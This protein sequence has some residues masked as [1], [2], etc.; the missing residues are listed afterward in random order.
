MAA[1]IAQYESAVLALGYVSVLMLVQ[2][3]IADVLG[4]ARKH[5]PGSSV[6]ADHSNLLFRASR[7]VGNINESIAIFLGGL[8][9]CVLSAA[10]PVYTAYAAWGYALARSCYAVCYYANLQIL[11][12]VCFGFSLLALASLLVVGVTT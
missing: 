7:A 8:L 10:S 1:L 4:V 2:L 11:R 3:L 6:E 5:S 12:S 9:F